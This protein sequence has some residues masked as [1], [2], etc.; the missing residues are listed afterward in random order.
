MMNNEQ[1][2]HDKQ[3]QQNESH[4]V[5]TKKREMQEREKL[6]TRQPDYAAIDI[7]QLK[8]RLKNS[9]KTLEN[10]QSTAV[11]IDALDTAKHLREKVSKRDKLDKAII[12]KLDDLKD[13]SK[14]KNFSAAVDKAKD[15]YIS[16]NNIT[17]SPA[18]AAKKQELERL[19][20]QI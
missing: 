19:K 12:S 18:P 3:V 1:I 6:E 11:L 16:H 2:R 14:S 17:Q 10:D 8:E 7:E 15:H 4:F 20:K 9:F 13:T 5:S